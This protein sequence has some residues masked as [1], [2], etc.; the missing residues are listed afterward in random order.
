MKNLKDIAY[1][2]MA[3][4]LAEKAIGRVSPNPYVGAIV[5]KNDIIV[6]YGYHEGPGK[7]HAEIVALEK[8]GPLSRGSTLYLTIEPCVHWGR[9]PPCIDKV[10]AAGLARVVIS[11]FDPNP[12]VNRRGIRRLKEAGIEVTEGLLRERNRRLNEFYRK[13]ITQ[14][15]PFV[16]LKAGLT[17]DGKMATREFDSRWISSPKTREYIHLLRGEY[18]ALMVGINTLIKDNPLLTIRHPNWGDKKLIRIVLDSYLRFPLNAS[19]LATLPS[20]KIIVFT[21][22]NSWLRKAEVLQKKGVDVIPLK[23]EGPLLNLKE[24][25]KELGKREIS[26]VLVEGGSRLL[27]SF[28]E[29]KFADKIYLTLSPKMIGGE[30]A[31]TLLEGKGVSQ[32][33]NSLFL[34]SLNSYR[35]DEDIILEGYF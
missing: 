29:E 9:T 30:K 21:L 19:I 6:G 18:D 28:I 26:S 7:P 8:A 11:D 5:V 14:K 32:I 34:Q 13:Y 1:L 3:F 10:L 17:L 16:T 20:G 33:K 35:M 2:S 12:L 23:G 27:T 31:L 22:A 25:L 24:V 4:G 15:I